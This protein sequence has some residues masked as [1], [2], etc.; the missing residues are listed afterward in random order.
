MASET[1]R[2]T[3]AEETATERRRREPG[4]LNRMASLKLAVPE[5]IR[6]ANEGYN[7][8]W[9]N[10]S[11]NRIYARTVQDD[12]EKVDGL[13]PRPV[14]TDQHGKPILAYLLRKR[15]EYW[16]KDQQEKLDALKVRERALVNAAKSDPSDSRPDD[17]AYAT[18]GNSIQSGYKP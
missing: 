11:D 1:K 3:A 6:K 7:L 12:W 18:P 17:M 2:P 13:D 16:D 4:T 8:R 15:T 10:D 14:G 9:S 5:N